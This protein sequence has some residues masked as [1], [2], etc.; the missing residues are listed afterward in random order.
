LDWGS[1]SDDTGPIDDGPENK[2]GGASN[3]RDSNPNDSPLAHLLADSQKRL[4]TRRT[5][6]DV[7]QLVLRH[8]Y[9]SPRHAGQDFAV[10]TAHAFGVGELPKRRLLQFF[11]DAVEVHS[12]AYY[13]LTRISVMP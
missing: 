6:G 13:A 5:M 7:V 2:R 1:W 12:I 9:D 4:E 3:G 8:L 10:R 11:A